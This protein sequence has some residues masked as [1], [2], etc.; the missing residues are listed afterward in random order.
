MRYINWLCAPAIVGMLLGC[1]P[2]GD[3]S[4]RGLTAPAERTALP[5][6]PSAVVGGRP[7][8]TTKAAIVTVP[9]G[10][11][12]CSEEIWSYVDAE[13]IEAAR[14]AQLGRNGLRAGL[15]RAD[16]WGDLEDVFRRL[17]GRETTYGV[18]T[19]APGEPGS[20]PI[21]RRRTTST[22]FAFYGDRSASG[23]DYPA[24][25]FL[26]TISC[27]IS[28]VD[29]D[30]LV[31]TV[32]PQIRS[33]TIET[34]IAE[35]PPLGIGYQSGQEVF[36]FDQAGFQ[37]SM[38]VGDMLVIGPG[39]ESQRPNSIGHHFLTD[40]IKGVP[41]ETVIVLIPEVITVPPR[42]VRQPTDVWGGIEEH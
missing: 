41:V 9:L 42:Q 28:E 18:V 26:L 27:A 40:R 24:G 20:L 7:I 33:A 30:R 12:S 13:P 10:A 31:L 35:T 8:V 2:A 6:P 34:R 5:G 36:S 3:D 29:R 19:A 39:A 17:S 37:L 15:V 16:S 14:S 11:A 1:S 4:G 32:L 23:A 25:E 21:K 38:P 22:I